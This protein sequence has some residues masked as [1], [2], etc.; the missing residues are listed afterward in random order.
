MDYKKQYN[1]TIKDPK[2][3][4]LISWAKKKTHEE[5]DQ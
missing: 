4:M 5:T 2:Q 1:I 3:P